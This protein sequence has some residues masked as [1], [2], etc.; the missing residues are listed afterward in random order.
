MDPCPRAWGATND[1][2]GA[3]SEPWGATSEPWGVT[4]EACE[5]TIEPWGATREAWG[6]W[7]GDANVGCWT[8]WGGRGVEVGATLG[9]GVGGPG[10]C[11]RELGPVWNKD[12]LEIGYKTLSDNLLT[13][14]Y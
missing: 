6:A 9:A 8:T 2:W 10:T 3:T 13:S 1:P 12:K 4:R 5:T 14:H 11:T 7:E